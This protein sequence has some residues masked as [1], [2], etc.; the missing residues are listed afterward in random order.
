MKTDF[1]R[2]GK[3]WRKYLPVLFLF[4]LMLSFTSCYTDYGLTTAD[5]DVVVTQYDKNTDF[6]AFKT[7]SLID[8]VFHITGDTTE[9]DSDL[10]TRKYDKLILSTIRENMVDYGYT[11]IKDPSDQNKPDVV[12]TVEALGTQIDQYYSGGWYPWY[13]WYPWWGYPGYPGYYPPYVGKSTYYVGT[14]FIDYFDVAASLNN[15]DNNFVTPWYATING[16]LQSGQS[17]SRLTGTINQA[18]E[19]SPYLKVK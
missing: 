6:G 16:L 13:G 2:N 5:Y 9:S 15:P 4:A 10:L 8:S 17:E 19:Q 3:I 14:L 12:L 11:E 7:F 1:K 18:F